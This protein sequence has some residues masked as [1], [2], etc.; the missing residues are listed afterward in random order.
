MLAS[1]VLKIIAD[2]TERCRS[3]D[4][5]RPQVV[6]ALRVL[7][8]PARFLAAGDNSGG[9]WQEA[10]ASYKAIVLAVERANSHSFRQTASPQWQA[11]GLFPIGGKMASRVCEKPSGNGRLEWDGQSVEVNYNLV[12]TQEINLNK[13]TVDDPNSTMVPGRMHV[14]RSL[15]YIL[16]PSQTPSPLHKAWLFLD[17]GRCVPVSVSAGNSVTGW[18]AILPAKDRPEHCVQNQVSVVLNLL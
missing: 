16:T 7:L 15:R 8:E 1:E 6:E 4:M 10:N 3:E 18:G 2:A 5:C 13:Q 17:D 9:R 12:V 14:N 11:V